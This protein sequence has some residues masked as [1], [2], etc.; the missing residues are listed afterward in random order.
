LL[1]DP[2]AKAIIRRALREAFDTAG[3]RL[4]FH[5]RLVAKF[6]VND[7]ALARLVDGFEGEGFDRLAAAVTSPP[8]RDRIAGA[9]HEGLTSLL[10]E[11]LG[12]RLKRLPPPR[13]SALDASIGDWL[14]DAARADGMRSSLR[15]ALL[16]G[17]DEAGE[18]TWDRLL[19]TMSPAQAA[20]FL[21]DALGKE[22]GRAWIEGAL[23][24][25]AIALLDRPIGRPADWIGPEEAARLRSAVT[26]S[27]WG[28]V[29][30]QLPMVVGRLNIPEIVEQKI[31]GFPLP[32]M[33]DII[34][35]VIE[36]ELKLI[37]QLGWVLG[38]I[39]GL[40]TF[41]VSLVAR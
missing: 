23:V 16:E 38:A 22:R 2:E 11:P 5:E 33:E 36:R 10:R 34:R 1:A 40:L 29:S 41:G 20:G 37:V 25:A 24:S 35:K 7:K 18:I 27:A 39:V 17:L 32:V 21:R 9:V 4:L 28:W 12:A 30:A 19:G 26:S 8:M 14:V 15:T 13:R 3:R 6:V 31:I